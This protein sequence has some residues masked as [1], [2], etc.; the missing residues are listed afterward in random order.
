M[1]MAAP[2]YYTADMVRA[3]PEDRNRYEV[4][5]G[6]LVVTPAPR[7]WRADRRRQHSGSDDAQ[8]Q[9]PRGGGHPGGRCTSTLKLL[10]DYR[11][12]WYAGSR[13]ST[14]A[15]NTLGRAIHPRPVGS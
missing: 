2:I 3:L 15:G 1:G 5:Y 6:E 9:E 14:W 4:V 10:L 11:P 8:A 12:G 7:P 13:C